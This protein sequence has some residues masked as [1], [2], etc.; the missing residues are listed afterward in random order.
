MKIL[1]VPTCTGGTSCNPRF[2]AHNIDDLGLFCALEAEGHEV[3]MATYYRSKRGKSIWPRMLPHIFEPGT[4]KNYDLVLVHPK[5]TGTIPFLANPAMH[6]EPWTSYKHTELIFSEL[7]AFDGPIHCYV[8][9]GRPAYMKDW[10]KDWTPYL[11]K[12]LAR[13]THVIS[14]ATTWAFAD[15]L[16]RVEVKPHE[17]RFDKWGAKWAVENLVD[18]T[19]KKYDFV[20]DGYNKLQ[21]YNKERRSFILKAAELFPDSATL[22]RIKIEGLAELNDGKF[23]NGFDKVWPLI[24]MARFR[25][26]TWEPYHIETKRLW[27][28]RTI[29][30]MASNSLA[31]TSLEDT[32]FYQSSLEDLQP[33]TQEQIDSQHQTL[34]EFAA[35][36]PWPVELTIG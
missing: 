9:D 33:P 4:I 31:F 10:T 17:S 34:K 24:T 25:P 26:L 36:E 2:N 1:Y 27:T 29:T 12:Q 14:E 8:N 28:P 32:P 13:E 11:E 15:V 18:S 6:G 19:E 23:A 16:K 35:N 30:A 5:I 21:N 7:A 20:F 3:T 22:G